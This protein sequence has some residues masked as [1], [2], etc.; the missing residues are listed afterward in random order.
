VLVPAV[1]NTINTV[2]AISLSFYKGGDEQ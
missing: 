2:C 1:V